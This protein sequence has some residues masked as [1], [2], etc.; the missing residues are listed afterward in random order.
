M[1]SPG[2]A[3]RRGRGDAVGGDLSASSGLLAWRDLIGDV[4]ILSK[5]WLREVSAA[6]FLTSAKASAGSSL[7][8]TDDVKYC[9]VLTRSLICRER[10]GRFFKLRHGLAA[11][12]GHRP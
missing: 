3:F 5:T 1:G 8:S 6:S 12:E 9:M 7:T 10:E 2:P 4:C 11:R